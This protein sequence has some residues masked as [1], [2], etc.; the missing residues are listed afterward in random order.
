M[1]DYKRDF[2]GETEQ[3]KC[4]RK[5]LVTAAQLLLTEIKGKRNCC[6]KQDLRKAINAVIKSKHNYGKLFAR[7]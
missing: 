6:I 5:K 1:K 3:A 4:P 2:H 7:H